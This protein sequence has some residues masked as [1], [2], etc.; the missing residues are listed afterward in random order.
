MIKSFID[1]LIM[2]KYIIYFILV[3]AFVFSVINV[4]IHIVMVIFSFIFVGVIIFKLRCRKRKFYGTTEILFCI[5][6][7]VSTFFVEQNYVYYIDTV[8]KSI[9]SSELILWIAFKVNYNIVDITL[10]LEKTKFQLLNNNYSLILTR[11]G[12]LYVIVRGLDN[13]D[14]GLENDFKNK[15][16]I[17][18]YKVWKRNFYGEDVN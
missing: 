14:K 11:L 15:K 18:I 8:F 12:S 13:V 17:K 9:T 2:T 6:G 10:F 3:L 16:H 7:F 4:N 1:S 5:I